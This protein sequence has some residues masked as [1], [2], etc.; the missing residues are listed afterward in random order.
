[1]LLPILLL[2]AA[3]SAPPPQ[4]LD[5]SSFWSPWFDSPYEPMMTTAPPAWQ[6]I[7][8]AARSS[9]AVFGAGTDGFYRYGGM[10]DCLRV[11][12]GEGARET[13]AHG[14]LEGMAG[15]P[16]LTGHIGEGYR[17]GFDAYN[18]AVIDWAAANLVPRPEQAFRGGT[19]Q[20]AYDQTFFRAVRLYA[21]AHA[22]LTTRYDLDAEAAAY[23]Q[24]M[25]T[26]P[27]FDGLDWLHAR[28][29]GVMA[30]AYP[31]PWDST[32]LTGP[33]AMG[34]WLRRHLDGT[35]PRL[36]AHLDELLERYDPAFHAKLRL[37]QQR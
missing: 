25:T 2:L 24:A 29:G 4:P 31:L 5:L 15:A 16:L 22:T 33:M 19:F 27:E 37:R 11:H 9:G 36:H 13:K 3:T 21:L 1:M 26:E 30:D 20:D 28:Y 8:P 18:P 17:R 35:A 34:F 23:R 32:M 6:D 12:H 10:W 7:P 14:W